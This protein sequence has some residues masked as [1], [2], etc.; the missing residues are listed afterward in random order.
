MTIDAKLKEA[1]QAH[2]EGRIED[3]ERL[4]RD[5][6]NGNPQEPFS[7]HYLGV[8]LHRRGDYAVAADLIRRSLSIAP[9]PEAMNNLGLVLGAMDQFEEAEGLF[10]RALALAPGNAETHNNLGNALTC[11]NKNDEAASEI[12]EAIRLKPD[13]VLAHYNLG[14]ALTRQGKIADALEAFKKSAALMPN[15]AEAYCSMGLNYMALGKREEAIE[16]YRKA[17]DIKPDFYEAYNNLGQPL[18]ELRRLDEAVEAYK[19][20]VSLKPDYIGATG[21]LATVLRKQGLLAEALRAYEE[22][23]AR[24]PKDEKAEIEIINLR[25]QI[26]EWK[27]YEADR[28]RLVELRDQVEPFIFLNFSSSPAEQQAC[29]QKWVS[30]MQVVP[31]FSHTRPRQPGRIRVGYLSS[32]FRSHATAFL[33]AELFERHDRSKFETFAYSFGFDDGSDMRQRLI[34]GFDRFADV[35]PLTNQEIAQRIY[36]DQIDILID[37][38]GFTG[39]SRTGVMAFRPAPIQVAHVGYPGTMGAKFIDYMIA[40]PFVAPAE[41][42]RFFDEKIVHLPYSYQPN[43]SKREISSRT[44]TKSECRLPENGFVFCSFNGS[45][46]ITPDIFGVWMRLLKAVPGSVLWLLSTASATESNLR[47]EAAA[48]GVEP[49]RL[50]FAEGLTLP[51]HLARHRLADLFLDTLP[52]CA[53]TTASDAL[54]AGLPVLTCV[55]GAFVGRVAG[56]LLNTM[57]LPELIS[58]SLAEYEMKAMELAHNPRKLL[59]IKTKLDNRRLLSPLFDIV[60]YTRDL[61]DAYIYMYDL[62]TSGQAPRSRFMANEKS[63]L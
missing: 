4:Y 32:D 60:R 59:D 42:Q 49:E 38:K 9:V 36:D 2:R 5:I 37:L 33:M 8:I 34:K 57:G 58:Y 53:H 21:N 51:F 23:F 13:F 41:H 14:V 40:D 3:A 12:L 26:C 25:R 43:D 10:R 6:L 62:R 30:R 61:E 22:G 24:A 35:F 19:K 17:I 45:Y 39:D 15:F 28:K 54:W 44:I 48:R 1:V 46:K 27:N 63:Q 20:A 55:G 29:T 16:A 11:L 52:I 7:L 56:S 50:I 31:E 47:R 18:C